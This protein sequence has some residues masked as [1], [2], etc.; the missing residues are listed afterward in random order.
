MKK[1]FMIAAINLLAIPGFAQTGSEAILGASDGIYSYLPF[2]Q[3]L[4][5]VIA[6]LIAIV[7][8]TSI[9]MAM[10]TSSQQVSKRIVTS[11]G[12]CLCFVCM[13]ISLPQFFGYESYS[14]GSGSDLALN[15]AGG[16]SN[17]FLTTDKGG[18][19]QS[20]INT[21]IPPLSDKTGN[22]ITFPPGSNMDIANNLMD[23]YNH[24]GSGVTG[25]YGRTLDYINNEFRLGN[26]SKNM[27]DQMIAMAGSLPHN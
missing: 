14:V 24:M 8:A 23:I 1:I 19:S 3:G 2:V 15:G 6:A 12:S 27:Y 13:A 7:G 25:T 26:I 5:Y 9:Y 16:S 18:I 22:W 21:T 20:G 11:V 4:C 10:Q 17:G